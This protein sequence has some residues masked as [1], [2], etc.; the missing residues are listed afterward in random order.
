MRKL[1]L[2][3]I[4]VLMTIPLFAQDGGDP[5]TMVEGEIITGIVAFEG[6]TVYSGPD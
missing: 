5:D 6:S 1:I 4:I 2:G 3:L